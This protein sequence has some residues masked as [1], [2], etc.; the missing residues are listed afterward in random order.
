MSQSRLTRLP[1]ALSTDLA[2][3]GLSGPVWGASNS[4]NLTGA[5]GAYALIICLPAKLDM[6][7][8]RFA[9]RILDEGWYVYC[10]SAWGSGGLKA[11]LGRHLRGARRPH[12]HID[13]LTAHRRP[14]GIALPGGAECGLVTGLLESA[15]FASP[16]PGFGSSDCRTC[17]SHLVRWTGP[18]QTIG[19]V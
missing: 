14:V 18:C 12:W 16:L 4:A 11:R 5:G 7:P 15:R 1:G 10:G 6:A 19:E 13:R 17:S 8:G 3:A 2:A 9:G